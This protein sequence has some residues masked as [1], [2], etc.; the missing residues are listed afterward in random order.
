MS[1][2]RKLTMFNL[3]IAGAAG[4]FWLAQQE[5]N[6]DVVEDTASPSLVDRVEDGSV[7]QDQNFYIS[8]EL[9]H[10]GD[11]EVGRIVIYP[12]LMG[13]EG[14]EAKVALFRDNVYN[15]LHSLHRRIEFDGMYVEGLTKDFVEKVSGRD[16]LTKSQIRG[17]FPAEELGSIDSGMQLHLLTEYGPGIVYAVKQGIT[18]HPEFSLNRERY[19]FEMH[20]RLFMESNMGLLSCEVANYA[21]N[22][23]ESELIERVQND[24]SLNPGQNIAIVYGH[25]HDFRDNIPESFGG[26]VY[27]V[28]YRSDF[29]KSFAVDANIQM[30]ELVESCI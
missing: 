4:L 7:E 10:D 28:D 24:L 16:S 2:I 15:G 6:V 11:P 5:P 23:R 1:L 22:G 18:L 29:Q 8:P 14:S 12:E 30:N 27:V 13:M 25:L 3:A 20:R 17:S 19:G 26:Q 9:I 21:S